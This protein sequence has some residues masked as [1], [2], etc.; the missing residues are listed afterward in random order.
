MISLRNAFTVACVSR[1]WF[2]GVLA[3]LDLPPPDLDPRSRSGSGYGL[4]GPK[5]LTNL[6]PPT[7]LRN[8]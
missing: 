3:D 2:H 8:R 4:P 6:D 7:K 1:M 5:P